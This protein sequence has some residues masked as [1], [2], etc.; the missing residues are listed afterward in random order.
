[1]D[2]G[3]SPLG[4]DFL[5]NDHLVWDKVFEARILWETEACFSFSSPKEDYCI[6]WIRFRSWELLV[7][8][9]ILFVFSG[10]CIY[11]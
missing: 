6:A 5:C 7:T 8:K 9:H 11:V 1:M 3:Q 2:Q 10:S 4:V